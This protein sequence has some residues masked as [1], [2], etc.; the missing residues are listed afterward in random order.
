M[1]DKRI[2]D[3]LTSLESASPSSERDA[4]EIVRQATELDRFRIRCL[5]GTCA[6]FWV[7]TVIGVIWLIGFYFLNVVPRL[8]A[9]AAGRLQLENDWKDWIRAF[10]AGAKIILTS[11]AAFLLAALGT[12]LLILTSRRATLRQINADLLDISNQLREIRLAERK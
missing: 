9:Y 8:D 3:A 1:S 7:V 6:F 4:S 5:A 12:L 2:G 10:N 11:M